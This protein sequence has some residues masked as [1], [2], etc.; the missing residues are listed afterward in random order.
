MSRPDNTTGPIAFT[1]RNGVTWWVIERDTR[2]DPGHRG[3]W[4]LVFANA[5]VVRRV[6]TYP[7]AWRALSDAELESL[8]SQTPARAA[9]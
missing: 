5:D 7:R 8:G 9:G 2:G 6:W 3:D 1:E 4:C